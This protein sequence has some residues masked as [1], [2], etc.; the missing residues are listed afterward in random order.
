HLVRRS[1]DRHVR[2]EDQPALLL[3]DLAVAQQP[4]GTALEVEPDDGLALEDLVLPILF[5]HVVDQGGEQSGHENPPA[6]GRSGARATFP[7]YPTDGKL[8]RNSERIA[9]MAGWRRASTSAR[10]ARA[11]QLRVG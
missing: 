2:V 8:N 7:F 3:I 9:R 11:L 1:V 6:A 5:L 10:I 4:A